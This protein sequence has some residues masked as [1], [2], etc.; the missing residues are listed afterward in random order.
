MNLN[1]PVA[2]PVQPFSIDDDS[3]SDDAQLTTARSSPTPQ[4]FQS[5]STLGG[6]TPYSDNDPAA[7]IHVGDT[8]PLFDDGSFYP[9]KPLKSNIPSREAE[10]EADDDDLDELDPS[11]P[12]LMEGLIGSNARRADLDAGR[13]A[14]AKDLES[15]DDGP[16]DWLTKG[17]GLLA[18]VANMS[19][20]ILGAGIIGAWR[21]RVPGIE[22]GGS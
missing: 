16:P 9:P 14:R 11:E 15:G 2:P 7:L 8:T 4:P 3:D 10:F 17:A 5:T 22:G 1:S 6:P 18:G 21:F 12:L 20:S 13:E 19:N